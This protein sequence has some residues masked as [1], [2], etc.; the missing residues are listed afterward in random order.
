MSL[1]LDSFDSIDVLTQGSDARSSIENTIS[2]VETV[3][4]RRRQLYHYPYLQARADAILE[5]LIYE[6]RCLEVPH[7]ATWR[8]SSMMR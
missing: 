6:L 2:E 3:T 4:T 5:I 8:V 1:L 7:G